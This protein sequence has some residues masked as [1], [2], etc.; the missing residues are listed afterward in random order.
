[1]SGVLEAVA[2][3]AQKAGFREGAEAERSAI[4]AWLRYEAP[5]QTQVGLQK[6][7]TQI[8]KHVEAEVHSPW[9]GALL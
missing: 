7:L 3:A 5:R 2:D 6:L 9:R 1:M 4:V 8:A